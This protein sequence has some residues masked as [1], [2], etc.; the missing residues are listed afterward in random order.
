MHSVLYKTKR[1]IY[2]NVL[3]NFIKVEWELS[4]Y[5]AIE[6]CFEIRGPVLAQNV[7]SSSILFTYSCHSR[8]HRFTAVHELDSSFPKEE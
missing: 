6:A 8:I 5:T 7:F 4:W 1:C 2:K 3:T